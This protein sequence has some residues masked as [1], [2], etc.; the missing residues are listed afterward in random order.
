M[1]DEAALAELLAFVLA[2]RPERHMDLAASTMSGEQRAAMAAV[3]EAVA[4]LA[5]T[6][7][8][9]AP[10]P[11]LRER[12]LSSLRA[13]V[14]RR[15]RRAVLVCDM[16][17]DH[18]SPGKPLEVPRAREIV[19][20]LAKRLEEARASGEPVVYIVD[21]HLPG[22]PE[23]DEWPTHAVEGTEGAAVWPAL[24]PQPSDRVV[25]KPAISGFYATELDRVLE[26]LGVDTLVVTGCATEVQLL[27]TA[28]D[29]LQ[30]GFLVEM[31]PPLQ[32][33]NGELGEIFTMGVISAL[34]PYAP[35]RRARLERIANRGGQA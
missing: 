26:E 23:L 27:A 9:A 20:A 3:T 33:G 4:H 1:T 28:T 6:E 8:P 10:S 2:G 17:C 25:I 13:R 35:A 30:R 7:P 24:A 15:P 32:A 16:I 14:A 21:R 12:I 11:A 29:A 5:H 22:D 34:A 18:L 31:P 19:P